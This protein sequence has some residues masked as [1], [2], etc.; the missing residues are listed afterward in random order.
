MYI[1]PT[2]PINITQNFGDRPAYYAQFGQKGHN[3]IDLGVTL[4]SPVR[5][6][7]AGVV[8]FAG[9]GAALDYVGAIAGKYILIDHGD[10]WTGYAH[11]DSLK[12]KI[13]DKVI[14]GQTIALAGKTGIAD[15]VHVHFEFIPPA[16]PV[17][18]SNGYWGRV[19]PNKYLKGE[20]M[21]TKQ[22]VIDYFRAWEGRSPTA[23]E[24]ADYT[25]KS[26]RYLADKILAAQ[27]AR[28]VAELA[29]ANKEF[30]RKM[31]FNLPS[32]V[33]AIIYVVTAV[34]TPVVTYLFAKAYIGEL[35]VTLFA[36]LVTAV[37]A[38]AALN[39][40]NPEKK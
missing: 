6:S 37:N 30:N 15:G 7:R 19:D 14:Q 40:Q 38:M 36:A 34:A 39:V 3:G 32:K 11:N 5:A 12:V 8:K 4:G 26:W 29:E 24:I 22:D 9:N 21:P 18:N 16:N 2:S 27:K 35:E 25:S 1:Y 13:G 28:H 31:R 33:R 17:T 23:S 20:V 10:M